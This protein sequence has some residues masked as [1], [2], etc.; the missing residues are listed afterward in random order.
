[1]FCMLWRRRCTLWF[2]LE[3][4]LNINEA[5]YLQISK[6]KD[7]Q[8]MHILKYIFQIHLLKAFGVKVLYLEEMGENV[9]LKPRHVY[10]TLF[11]KKKKSE[12]IKSL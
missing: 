11:K 2:L 12:P 9:H 10:L 1:M 6:I 3:F 5:H 7:M 4:S 8:R